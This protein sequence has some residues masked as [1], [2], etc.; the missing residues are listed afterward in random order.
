MFSPD[1]KWLAYTSKESGREEVYVRPFPGS[2]PKW[3][4][5]TGGGSL[6]TWSRTKPELFFGADGRI[7][8]TTFTVD[9]PTFHSTEPRL[10]SEGRYQTRGPNRMF[11]LHPDGERVALAP[12]PQS[13]DNPKQDHVFLVLNFFQEL[14][15]GAP[16]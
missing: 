9:G 8:V 16:Q 11:D 10:W 12:A 7:M 2:E 1:G 15:R 13:P 6:P 3:Q 5:S 4:I 14:R